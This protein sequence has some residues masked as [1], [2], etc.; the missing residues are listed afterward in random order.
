LRLT[1][2]ELSGFK[3][4][5]RKTELAFGRGITAVIGP[6]GSGKS[7]IADAIRWVL[8]EQSAR[9]L[10]GS[11]MEDVI[12]SGTQQRKSQG[13]CEVTL[14]FDNADGKLNLPY[15]EIAVT[16]RLYRSGESEYCLNRANCRL[17]DIQELFR[18]TGIGKD[19]YSIISQGKV[20]EILSN[21][22]NDRRVALE[23]AAGVMRYRVRKEEAARKLDHTEK[24]LE[25]IGDIL[26]ELESRLGP[27][28]EQSATA[29][30]YLKLRDELK[31]L[32][33]N[34]F[35][36]QYDRGKERL[37]NAEQTISQIAEQ[38][39]AADAQAVLLLDTCQ[40]LEQRSHDLD[41]ALT[42]QQSILMTML[43]GV[44][45]QVGESKVLLERR[46]HG[47]QEIRRLTQALETVSARK[48]ELS[49]TLLSM[50][51]DTAAA[52]AMEQLERDISAAEQAVSQK[53]QELTDAENALEEMKNSIMEA[54][55]RLADAKGDLSR[56]DAMQAAISARM[57]T[58][59]AEMEQTGGASDAL[60][61]E[62][63]EAQQALSEQKETCVHTQNA[64]SDAQ[65]NRD[66]MRTA[67]ETAQQEHRALEQET[68]R[69]SSRLRVLRD[70]EKSHEGYYASVRSILQDAD[71]E[72]RLR[73]AIV[74]V[75]AELITVPKAYETAINMALGSALQ[76]IVTPTADDARFVIEYLRSHDYGRATLLPMALLRERPLNAQE[77][78]LLSENG[79]L[80]LASELISCEASAKTAVSYLLGRTV[81][82]K[83]LASGV[84]MKKKS[85]GAFQIAT[86]EGDIISTGGAMSGGSMKKRDFSLLG[87]K[88][89]I[90]DLSKQLETKNGALSDLAERCE[91]KRK[92]ILM[93]E[94]QIEAF[95]E[96]LHKQQIEQTKLEEKVDIIARDV[97]S[98]NAAG[99]RLSE[100]L[101]ALEE[102]LRDIAAEREEALALQSRLESGSTATKDDVRLAQ[103][104]LGMLRQQRETASETLTEQKIRRMALEKEQAAV[105][106]ERR[107]LENERNLSEK[108]AADLAEQLQLQQTAQQRIAE[109]LA[110][111]QGMIEQEQQN[112]AEQKKIQ[113]SL[114]EER[115]TLNAS[116]AEHRARRDGLLAELR[117]L[118][119]RKH[120]QELLRSRTEMELTA[121][122]DRIWEDYELTYENA[123]PLRREIAI[124]ATS[125]RISTIRAEIR[126]MGDINLSAIED[127]KAVSER[128]TSLSTQRD[129]LLRAETDLSKLIDELTG[130]MEKVF[131]SQFTII[132]KNF[133]E[134][135]TELFGGGHAELRLSDPNDVLGCDID[136][137]AQPPGKKLQLLSLLSGGERA[138][139][140]IALLFAMLRLK[141]PAFCVLDE[142]E[143]SLDEANVSRFADYLK[144][145]SDETQFIIITHRKGSMEVCDSLYG[146]SMEERG[147]SK[148]VSARFGNSNVS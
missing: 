109:R 86:L 5:A 14:T 37:A 105:E 99:N 108:S 135:F 97:E 81:I 64:L 44:E 75:V 120:K 123:L 1:K 29:R 13:Y 50:E 12:F 74:G 100:E 87:R 9:A 146:V 128:F 20:D 15:S 147:V 84:A 31:D 71:R 112:A 117:E 17:R 130:T 11:K 137:I 121:M 133:G 91:E 113:H 54:M 36:Y 18:D 22:S 129:D 3:S 136:I 41:T 115:E 102:N 106:N 139:T 116:L 131:T 66:A 94:L 21:R 59:R 55:N 62:Y 45:S 4:F 148:V 68:D 30:S 2:L 144:E 114:E 80:G 27:L 60:R 138:L 122:Q 78:S 57:E 46:E 76:N 125:S 51:A 65:N 25:R 28:E 143:S 95:R 96:E 142:I 56:F 90:E 8:G 89:E 118:S 119:E 67:F 103:Q 77:R 6:N 88:R 69:L 58:I 141:P 39:V 23:E 33:V 52:A 49:E 70:M 134:V 47:E 101:S 98:G 132:Q 42:E 79:C 10:R 72:P 127:Y 48:N 35:L 38:E 111:M 24:N 104:Q 43:S 7:N 34:Q 126:E 145:Y 53:D 63:A 93:A 82:V 61:A 92:A 26:E 19:G 140:A 110:E 107:R 73:A 124:G 32:E 85:G 83:D 16:R 40:E